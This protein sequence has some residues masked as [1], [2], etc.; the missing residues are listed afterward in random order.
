MF[1]KQSNES[2]DPTQFEETMKALEV[3]TST[4]FC[5]GDDIG[6]MLKHS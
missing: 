5:N 1:L 3:Y 2:R 4:K 6:S